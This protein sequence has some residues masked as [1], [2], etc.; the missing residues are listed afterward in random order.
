MVQ[1]LD[2]LNMVKS[3]KGTVEKPGKNVA[4]VEARRAALPQPAVARTKRRS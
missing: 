2:I 1:Q 4:Q 3:T